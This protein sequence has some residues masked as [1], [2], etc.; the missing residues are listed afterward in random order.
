MSQSREL[1]SWETLKMASALMT[2]SPLVG[3]FGYVFDHDMLS[4]LHFST[5]AGVDVGGFGEGVGAA[6][7]LG[8]VPPPVHAVVINAVAE[9]PTNA[10][11]MVV[12]LRLRST[13]ICFPSSLMGSRIA[14]FHARGRGRLIP[15]DVR[16]RSL[17][18][19]QR[20]DVTR[21][22]VAQERPGDGGRPSGAQSVIDQEDRLSRKSYVA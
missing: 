21:A 2:G 16:S 14:R 9:S 13:D 18:H 7:V 19:H 5:V 12:R 4:A 3:W 11:V 17:M 22:R 15:V 10:R 20:Q 6:D 8:V 1:Q